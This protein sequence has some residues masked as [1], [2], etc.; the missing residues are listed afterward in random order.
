[1][2]Y[3]EFRPVDPEMTKLTAGAEGILAEAAVGVVLVNLLEGNLE[4]REGNRQ[5][6][7]QVVAAEVVKA[8]LPGNLLTAVLRLT[9]KMEGEVPFLAQAVEELKVLP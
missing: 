3:E 1:M 7:N 8:W 9:V 5:G 4:R 6:R 2:W